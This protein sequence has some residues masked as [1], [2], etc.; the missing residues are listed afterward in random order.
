MPQ[1]VSQQN[2]E[3]FS[4]L[5][6]AALVSFGARVDFLPAGSFLGTFFGGISPVLNVTKT[7]ES[8]YAISND[9]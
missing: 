2:L 3:Q 5:P 8:Q 6:L 7:K 1:K 9:T 4:Y